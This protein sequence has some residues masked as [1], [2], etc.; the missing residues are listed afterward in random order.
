M[1]K[2]NLGIEDGCS[3]AR[4]VVPHAWR[5]PAESQLPWQ[6]AAAAAVVAKGLGMATTMPAKAWATAPVATAAEAWVASAAQWTS[7]V[8]AAAAAAVSVA[9]SAIDH[10]LTSTT[11][12]PV[13]PVAEPTWLEQHASYV[14]DMRIQAGRYH[15][16]ANPCTKVGS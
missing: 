15:S 9:S 8:S 11:S 4:P 5:S 10:A 2:D 12:T 16:Y 3:W 13:T 14:V 7:T 1:H 6:V